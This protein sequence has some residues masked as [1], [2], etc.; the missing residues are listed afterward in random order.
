MKSF[1]EARDAI[2]DKIIPLGSERVQLLDAVG[3]VLAE[4]VTSPWPMPLC[5]NSAMDGFAVR[6][7]DC[8]AG[9]TLSVTDYI[10]AGA[11]S[12]AAVQPGCAARIMTGAPVPP[13]ADAVVP[14]EE[15][16]EG[17]GTVTLQK[18]V[19][20]WAHIRFAGEDVAYGDKV[21]AA[22]TLLGPAQISMLASCGAALV[23]VYRI[24]RVA[25]LSTGDELVELGVTPRR[26]EILNSNTFAV[27]AA[28]RLCGAEPAILGI[29][30]D[31]RDSH[32]ALLS[33]GL[34]ADL[35]ITS[36]GVS[37]GDRDLVRETLAELGVQEVFWKV[38]IR[39][40]QPLAFGTRGK[41]PVFSLPGNPVSTMI[42]FEEFVRPAILRMMGHTEVKRRT[43]TGVLQQEVRKKQ[44]RTHFIRARV[45]VEGGRYLASISGDQNT[46]I[47]RT[48]VG[49]NALVILPEA[50]SHFPAGTEVPM[51][52]LD[53][54]LHLEE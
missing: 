49:A 10:P 28:T 12:D 54:S 6:S 22:G 9:V 18:D 13:G 19:K 26:G 43:V 14:L 4:D 34:Q 8:S 53:P 24:P 2:L 31:E 45:S 3:R 44:G 33:E 52:L 25:I 17:T 48:M 50:G 20:Q 5:D 35:L 23:P 37:A 1:E 41:V 38:A 15:C 40:G 29:A 21:L 46:G 36:A 30:R 11:T 51:H 16:T 42:T 47:L 32:I 27:A 39:P 7:A